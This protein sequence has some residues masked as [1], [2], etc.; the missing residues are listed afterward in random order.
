MLESEMQLLE[1]KEKNPTVS[2]R[3]PNSINLYKN[4]KKILAFIITT[5]TNHISF[6]L[7]DNCDFFFVNPIYV[8]Y[9][10][11]YIY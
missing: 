6:F 10:Y 3:Y 4:Y 9:I 2:R 1:K 7:C 5:K 8:K 11:I